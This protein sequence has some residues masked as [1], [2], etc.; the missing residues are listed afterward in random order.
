MQ[1]PQITK[2][3]ERCCGCCACSAACPAEAIR[4]S[5]DKAGFLYPLVD[6][7]KCISCGLCDS[8]C[9][10]ITKGKIID[11]SQA[12][13][14]SA[15]E[16]TIL[17]QSSSGGIFGLLAASVLKDDGVVYGAAFNKLF[18]GVNHVR[19]D[20]ISDL[21]KTMRS[22]YVQGRV[23]PEIYEQVK[24][25]V[26]QNRSVLYSGTACQIAGVK[27]YLGKQAESSNFLCIDVICHGV[28]SPGLWKKWLR[29]HEDEM[30]SKAD[31]VNF[32]DKSTG[33]QDYSI[34]YEFESGKELLNTHSSD[35]YM[36]T[37]LSNASLRESCF[38][39]PSKRACGSDITLGDFL[40]NTGLFARCRK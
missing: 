10:V 32:R 12:F 38:D 20:R 9:P 33:W 6:E 36:K 28:P 29:F 34:S 2:L 1:I 15:K 14:A 30:Q 13:W 22:K 21:E 18:D 35:W 11:V 16:E 4:L 37:F 23:D 19:I 25:D 39:C 8:T 17:M 31:N 27:N 7:F 24:E 3:N 40:G 5:P 26:E